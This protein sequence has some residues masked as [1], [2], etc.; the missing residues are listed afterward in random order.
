MRCDE[1]TN[2]RRHRMEKR[3]GTIDIV[4]VPLIMRFSRGHHFCTQK[5]KHV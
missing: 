3:A 2:M 5:Q 1:R 4:L